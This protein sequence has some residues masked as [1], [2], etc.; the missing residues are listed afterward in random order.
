MTYSPED[1]FVLIDEATGTRTPL[2]P[3]EASELGESIH[4]AF[5]IA[6][7]MATKVRAS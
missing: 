2:T 3:G 5:Y 6:Q 7:V 4:R 1:G